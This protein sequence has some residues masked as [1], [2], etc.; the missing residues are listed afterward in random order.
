MWDDIL[1]PVEKIIKLSSE[2]IWQ[3]IKLRE[4]LSPCLQ[5]I[6]E[7]DSASMLD[8]YKTSARPMH[9]FSDLENKQKR[10]ETG[11]VWITGLNDQL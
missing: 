4:G 6:K 10:K 2:K 9:I 5:Q 11:N 8:A 7:S 3:Y 1:N